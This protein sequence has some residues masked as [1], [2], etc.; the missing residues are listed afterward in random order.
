MKTTLTTAQIIGALSRYYDTEIEYVFWTPDEGGFFQGA[1]IE[2]V[3]SIDPDKLLPD[4][5]FEDPKTPEL[6]E[7]TE[8]A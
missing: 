6:R 1:I 5:E 7:G 4:A 2:H 8:N 3:Y